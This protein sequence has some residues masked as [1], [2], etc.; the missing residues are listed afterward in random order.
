MQSDKPQYKQPPLWALITIPVAL[1]LAI[2]VAATVHF[3][4]QTVN[5]EYSRA[6][7]DSLAQRA[8][9]DENQLRAVLREIQR[10]VEFLRNTPPIQG[11]IRARK[12]AGIDPLDGSSYALW[13]DR[14]SVIFRAILIA[15][16]EYLQMRFIGLSNNGLELVRVDRDLSTGLISTP[17]VL[18]E[19]LSRPYVTGAFRGHPDE[20]YLS[21]VDLNREFGEIQVPYTPVIRASLP[22]FDTVTQEPFGV[23]VINLAAS[24]LFDALVGTDSADITRYVTNHTGEYLVAPAGIDTFAFEFDRRSNILDDHPHLAPLFEAQQEFH[25]FDEHE[26]LSVEAIPISLGAKQPDAGLALVLT[27]DDSQA[28]KLVAAIRQKTRAAIYLVLLTS[29]ICGYLLAVALA[30]PLRKLAAYYVKQPAMPAYLPPQATLYREA[31]ALSTTLGDA[32]AN[33]TT[34][35]SQLQAS[36]RE[37]DQFAYIASHDLQEPVRS[38]KTMAGMISQDPENVLSKQSQRAVE[39][40]DKST[41]R[42]AELIRGLLDY[43]RLGAQRVADTVDLN[44]TLTA[45]RE[46]LRARLEETQGEIVIANSLPTLKLYALEVRLLFQNLVSNSIKFCPP[47]RTPRV[48]IRAQK[49]GTHEWQFC[50]IDNGIGIPKGQQEKIFL[51]FQRANQNPQ[52]EGTGIGLAHCRKIAEMHHGRIW[53][54]SSNANGTSICLTL[55]EIPHDPI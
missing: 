17:G 38:I 46:D 5:A 44:K 31:A 35:N 52:Y 43:S 30:M 11:L 13:A 18:Q 27:R 16:P 25:Q 22:V 15:K 50:V 36:N 3:L 54:E 6:L 10:D 12:N 8:S 23:I 1:L 2:S 39:Y 42:M 19:K 33:L 7:Q 28:R 4:S 32:F 41:T 55:R 34:A 20:V 48:E 45:I 14:L 49:T 24:L 21:P 26:G 51:I 47:E 37:L 9:R 40:L 53:V 29:V